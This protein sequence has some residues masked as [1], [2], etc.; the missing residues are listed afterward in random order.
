[1][2]SHDLH[3]VMAASD[4]VIC[5]NGHVCWEGKPTV[6]SAAPEYR[7]CSGFGTRERSRSTATTTTSAMAGEACAHGTRTGRMGKVSTSTA[8]GRG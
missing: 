6:V 1:M 2:V 7:R 3:M 4:R 8:P 5:L